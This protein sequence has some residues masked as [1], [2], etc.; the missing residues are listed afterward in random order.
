MLVLLLGLMGCGSDDGGS[1]GRDAGGSG[2]SGG[3]S[4]GSF[5]SISPCTSQGSYTSGTMISIAGTSYSPS[6]LRVA[7]GTAVSIAASSTHPLAPRSGGSA[8]NPIPSQTS[9]ATVTFSAPGFYPF[10]C[11]VHQPTM[12]GVVWVE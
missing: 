2:G 6:C 8:N 5:T 4:G 10:H 3:G 9:A 7:A 1:S 11:T 12:A